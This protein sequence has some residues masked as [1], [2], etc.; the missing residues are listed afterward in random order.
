[1]Q[2]PAEIP[3]QQILNALLDADKPLNPLFPYRLSDLEA[4]EVEQ[5]AN[6][7]PDVPVWRRQALMEDIE[8]LTIKDTLLYY[9]TLGCFAVQDDDPRVRLLAVR[10]LGN[11]EDKFLIPI[12]LGLLQNDDDSQVRAAA[13]SALSLAFAFGFLADRFLACVLLVA[14]FFVVFLTATVRTLRFLDVSDTATLAVH[15]DSQLPRVR[16]EVQATRRGLCRFRGCDEC[17][18]EFR[19]G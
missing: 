2:T 4:Q 7:W 17:R 1:M 11:Y 8:E 9:V 6:I 13:A 10:T 18:G 5:L 3:F 14:A 15:Q 12:F 19:R 16:G